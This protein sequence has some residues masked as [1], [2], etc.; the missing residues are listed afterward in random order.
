[1]LN[2]FIAFKDSIKPAAR[3]FFL[4]LIIFPFCY[5]NNSYSQNCEKKDPFGEFKLSS[6]KYGLIGSISYTEEFDYQQ[7]FPDSMLI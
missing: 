3:L 7:Y 4:L 1:M 2:I 6:S 5:S